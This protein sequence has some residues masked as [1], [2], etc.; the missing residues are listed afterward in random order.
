MTT[1]EKKYK[2]LELLMQTDK[3]S[4]IDKITDI[5][6]KS[7]HTT[8]NEDF[9]LTQELKV[10]LDARKD[11]YMNGEGESYTWDEVKEKARASV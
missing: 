4:V 5:L 1:I 11:R 8:N 9:E 6:L 10:E 3:D 2:A 7:L